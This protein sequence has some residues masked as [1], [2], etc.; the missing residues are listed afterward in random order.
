M[1]AL[2]VFLGSLS[3]FLILIVKYYIIQD[4]DAPRNK[5]PLRGSM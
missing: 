4:M 1:Q 5:R 3:H 2:T